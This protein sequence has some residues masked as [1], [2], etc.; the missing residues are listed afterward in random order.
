MCMYFKNMGQKL[1][2]A[3][4]RV[5]P[6]E[7]KVVA[8]GTNPLGAGSQA[9]TSD[10]SPVPKTLNTH[11]LRTTARGRLNGGWPCDCTRHDGVT[12]AVAAEGH[13]EHRHPGADQER[14][15]DAGPDSIRE[16]LFPVIVAVG[17]RR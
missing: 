9:G 4:W 5:N 10:S 6:V 7:D 2:L 1:V 13:E 11:P 16:G 17:R 8:H 12:F 3:G 14:C 15:D